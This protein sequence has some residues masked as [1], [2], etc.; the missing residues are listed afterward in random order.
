MDALERVELSAILDFFA[1][2]PRDVADELDLAVLSVDEGAAFSIGADPKPL[3]FNRAL[4]LVDS[5]RLVDVEQWFRSR[6][7]PMVVSVRP[8]AEF[9]RHLR[10]RS[11]RRD[12]TYVKFR[13]GVS[14]AP[15]RDTSLRIEAVTPEHAGEFGR[16][17]AAVFGVP[18]AMARW[19]ASLCG[20]DRWICFGAFDDDLL[21]GT[22]ATY[23]AGEHAWLG[24]ATTV[25][26]ARGRGAQNAILAARIRAATEAGAHVLSVETSDRTDGV[27]GPA[28]RNV[29]RAGFQEAYRQQWWHPPNAQDGLGGHS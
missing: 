15:E 20:R 9:E 19:F 25:Q 10:A 12:R 26:D 23:I 3:L 16:V 6:G 29:V 5:A 4:G 11:Y 2:A 7:S 22:G 1:A 14:R 8:G 21:V 24:V 17:V 18:E 27:A 13:R 28:F